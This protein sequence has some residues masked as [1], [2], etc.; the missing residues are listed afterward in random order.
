MQKLFRRKNKL[1]TD[2]LQ[3]LPWSRNVVFVF[4]KLFCVFSVVNSILRG[5]EIGG[6]APRRR[7]R[8]V[9]QEK[10]QPNSSVSSNKLRN[11]K[12]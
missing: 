8:A 12:K 9:K 10:E 7:P 1:H 3:I 4:S 2:L 11:K 6:I 5:V